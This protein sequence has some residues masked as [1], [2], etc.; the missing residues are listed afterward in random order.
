MRLAPRRGMNRLANA[1]LT[2]STVFVLFCGSPAL[3][4]D[5]SAIINGRSIHVDASEEWNENNA[6]LGIEYRLSGSSLWKKQ[7]MLNGFRDS[8]NEMSYMAGA[9]LHRTLFATERL[10]GFYIDAGIN[11]FLMTRKD[12]NDN[13]PFPG[14][15]PS[16]TVGNRHVGVNLTYLPVSAVERLFDARM[17][18]ETVSGIV[19]LQV[20]VGIDSLLPRQD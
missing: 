11:A 8:N 12:V 20:K 3:A 6:G 4:G 5:W 7:L 1:V 16:L 14:A 18:D 15:V 13:R 19:F 9:G 2:L 17:L 10:Q